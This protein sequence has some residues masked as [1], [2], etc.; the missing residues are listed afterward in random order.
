MFG[1]PDGEWFREDSPIRPASLYGC[2]K[3]FGHSVAVTYR[4][5][6]EMFVS[7]GILG[8]HESRLQDDEFLLRHVSRGVRLIADGKQDTLPLNSLEGIRDWGFT[9][10]YVRAMHAMLQH[11]RP[12]DFVIATGITHSVEDV[13]RTA[14]AAAGVDDWRPYVSVASRDS[15]QAKAGA[16]GDSGK[17]RELLGWNAE[18]SFEDLV[19]AMVRDEDPVPCFGIGPA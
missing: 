3:A 9:G 6:H 15:G 7:C 8:N 12:E 17:A 19:A 16:R 18:V 4:K 14:F 5:R 11:E 1:A 10:D 13:V 2:A